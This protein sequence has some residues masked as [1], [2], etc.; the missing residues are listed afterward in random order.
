MTVINPA[1]MPSRTE[2]FF[3]YVNGDHGLFF[4]LIYT[5]SFTCSTGQQP[6]AAP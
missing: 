1:A 5:S 3:D 6:P 2:L 4:D